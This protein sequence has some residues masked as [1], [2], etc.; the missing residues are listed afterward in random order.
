[1]SC[2]CD[3]LVSESFEDQGGTGRGRGSN[4]HGPPIP[5]RHVSSVTFHVS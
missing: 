5:M 4:A 1:M 3:E 2:G